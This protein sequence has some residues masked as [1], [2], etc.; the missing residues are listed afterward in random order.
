MRRTFRPPRPPRPAAL[1]LVVLLAALGL[2]AAGHAQMPRHDG[3]RHDD[4]GGPPPA[5]SPRVP[6]DVPG[7]RDRDRDRTLHPTP[8]ERFDPDARARWDRFR[9]GRYVPPPPPFRPPGHRFARLPE[10][11]HRFVLHD[12]VYFY[13]DGFFLEPYLGAYIV[14]GAPIGARVPYLPAGYVSFFI[15]PRR[16]FFVNATY[17]LWDPWDLDYLVVDKP[18]GAEAAMG[19]GQAGEPDGLFVYPAEGQSEEQMRQD[20]YECHEWAVR[21]TGFDPTLAAPGTRGQ[22]DYRRAMKACLEAR[23]YKVE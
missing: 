19:E 1:G 10:R 18:S 12:R 22:S 16:Y 8:R 17:Y 2:P 14:V 7:V 20:R 4:R 21:Q 11:H 9:T 15:G 23:G 3:H 5:V 6:P 13:A